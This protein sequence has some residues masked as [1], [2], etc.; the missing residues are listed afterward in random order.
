MSATPDKDMRVSY[1]YIPKTTLQTL[2]N[3]GRLKFIIQDGYVKVRG[4]Y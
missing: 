4:S 1:N 3:P 2:S